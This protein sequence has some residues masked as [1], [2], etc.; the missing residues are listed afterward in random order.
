M[1]E[2]IHHPRLIQR[3]FTLIELIV[4][5]VLLGV[6]ASIGVSMIT[7]SFLVTRYMNKENSAASSARYAMERMTREIREADTNSITVF[8]A[9]DLR[10]TRLG[11]SVN[12]ALQN[13]RIALDVTPVTAASPTL[14]APVSALTLSYF[15]KNGLTTSSAAAIRLVNIDL[16]VTPTDGRPIRL[17]N[18]V[19]IRN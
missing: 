9:T 16:T 1:S 3:G 17:N 18:R 15:D 5:A 2:Y 14:L 7:D 4:A 8:T 11:S 13:G 19:A 6:L 10:F 12:I